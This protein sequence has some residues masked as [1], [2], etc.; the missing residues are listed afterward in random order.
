VHKSSQS[1]AGCLVGGREKQI[2]GG[3]LES[4]VRAGKGFVDRNVAAVS[5]REDLRS[6]TN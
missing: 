4:V 2:G 6:R 1:I 5:G 3:N